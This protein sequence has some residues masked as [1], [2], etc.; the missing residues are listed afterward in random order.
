MRSFAI[1]SSKLFSVPPL[2]NV[3]RSSAELVWSVALASRTIS[4]LYVLE[5]VEVYV[6]VVAATED[7]RSSSKSRV[8]LRSTTSVTGTLPT[9]VISPPPVAAAV[10]VVASAEVAFSDQLPFSASSLSASYSHDQLATAAVGWIAEVVVAVEASA[11]DVVV[12][13]VVAAAMIVCC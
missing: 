7:E 12:D 10:V 3:S 6:V 13:V 2:T 11:T 8:D 9:V 4:S 1:W 5:V